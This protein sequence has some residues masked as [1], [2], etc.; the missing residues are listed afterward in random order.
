M[1]KIAIALA[2]GGVGKTTSAVN[3]AAGL[4]GKNQRVLLID[5]D[6][7]GQAARSLGIQSP[8]GLGELALGEVSFEE[9]ISSARDNLW[10]LSGGPSLAG[11]KMAISKKEFGGEQTLS[12]T[13][14][15]LDDR[16]DYVI[17]DTAPG[18]DL[19]TINVLF[20]VQEILAPVSL[21]VLTLRGLLDFT[22]NI[23][24]IQQYHPQLTLRYVVPTF[25]D[26]RVRKSREILDQLSAHFSPQLCSPIRYNVRLSEAPGYGQTI[27]EYS[28]NSTGA[29]DYRI[30]TERIMQ[31]G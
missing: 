15:G 3:L 25:M 29:E 30:L 31:D 7:Q 17:I 21:E 16:Y 28:P 14:S 19:L 10:L 5:A 9:A 6:T 23:S 1:R 27:Y 20:Y 11:L 13:I 24:S 18:W 2:K 8:L 22:H 26:R 12:E 4:A